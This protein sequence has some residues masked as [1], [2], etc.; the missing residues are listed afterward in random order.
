MINIFLE[1]RFSKSRT[2]AIVKLTYE[3]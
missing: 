3:I 1:N 2:I